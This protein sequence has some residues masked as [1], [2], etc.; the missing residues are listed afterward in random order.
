MSEK[1]ITMKNLPE[2]E[3]PYEKCQSGGAAALSDAELLA[4]IIRN[5]YQGERAIDI[6]TDILQSGPDGLLNIRERTLEELM[7]IKGIGKV[8]AIQLKCAAE[9]SRRMAMQTYRSGVV[10]TNPRTVADYYMECL[11][12]EKREVL[13]MSV[14]DPAG[15]LL[16]EE[17]ISIGTANAS[18]IS[19]S[20]VFKKALQYRAGYIILLHN[21]PSGDPTPSGYDICMTEELIEA[22]NMIG[23]PLADHIIIGDRCYYSFLD[24]SDLDLPLS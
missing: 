18:L 15:T 17:I 10:M 4:V 8:K 6:A 5:G 22:G 16:G 12:H 2:S 9:L 1:N 20:E 19:V 13:L 21:H 24:E 3:R 7:Q 11:R 23:I 14:F